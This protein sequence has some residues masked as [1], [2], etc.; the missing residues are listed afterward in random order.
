MGHCVRAIIGAHKDIQR[1]ENNGFAKGIKLP[2]RYGMIF[3]TDALL[4]NI[5]ELFESANEPSDPETVTSYLLQEYSF[6][7][8]L[9]YIEADY[10][11]GIGTHSGILYENGK[12]SIPLC[13][14][15]GA[16]NILLRELGVW[17]EVNKDEFD[18]LNL[19][20]YRRMDKWIK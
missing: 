9:A 10:S 11:S 4:D 19:G 3:L 1:I 14:G 6:H 13:S 20:I 16:I 7:T 15:E 5:G 17:R 18:S 8:K 2:Q 12:I